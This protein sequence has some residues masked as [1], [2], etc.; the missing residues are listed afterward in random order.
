M[1]TDNIFHSLKT[2][3]D[4]TRVFGVFNVSFCLFSDDE[5]QEERNVSFKLDI[6]RFKATFGGARGCKQM[7][8]RFCFVFVLGI[9]Q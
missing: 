4:E 3:S 8:H 5:G 1:K 7:D 9:A 2:H 6:Y